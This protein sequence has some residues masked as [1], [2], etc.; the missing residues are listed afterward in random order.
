[1]NDG[2]NDSEDDDEFGPGYDFSVIDCLVHCKTALFILLQG[3]DGRPG[4]RG[5]PGRPGSKVSR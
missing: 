3:E 2:D 4:K 1:M 5:P